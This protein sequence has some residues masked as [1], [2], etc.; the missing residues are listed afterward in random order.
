MKKEQ[1]DELY[2]L[3][4]V[5][6]NHAS[7]TMVKTGLSDLEVIDTIGGLSKHLLAGGDYPALIKF[8]MYYGR[9]FLLKPTY[10]AIEH[11]SWQFDRIIELGAGTG[12]LGRGLSAELDLLPCVFI[13]KRPWVLIDTIA[14]LET[15]E[16][17][18]EVLGLLKDGDLLVMADL[19][20]CLK[21]PK[22]I[23]SCFSKWPMA[24]LEYCSTDTEYMES[25][26]TQIARYGA[27]PV[28]VES[29][30]DMF[31]DR[32]VEIVDLD[33]YILILVDKEGGHD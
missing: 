29:Y 8:S 10:E 1:L 9:R 21:T 18:Q 24:I 6:S 4:R 30:A 33:P 3:L 16:G 28:M 20:H 23:M 32:E 2:H 31:P 27:N 14:D 19:L 13:D 25:Y 22:E 5:A 11:T 12:W 7:N 15:K 17:R 26:T